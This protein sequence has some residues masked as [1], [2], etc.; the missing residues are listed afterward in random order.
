MGKE[1]GEQRAYTAHDSLRLLRHRT[2]RSL[3]GPVT[4]TYL[5]VGLKRDHAQT[6]QILRDA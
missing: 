5:V 1:K 2:C 4:R 3:L 6:S